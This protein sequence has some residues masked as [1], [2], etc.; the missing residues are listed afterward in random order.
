M[1]ENIKVKSLAKATVGMTVPHLNLR[2]TWARKGAVQLVPFELLEQA[3]FEPG[4]EYLFKTGIL[5]I[6]DLQIRIRLG[7]EEEEATPETAKMIELTDEKIKELL[8]QTALK[9][10]RETIDG[11][12][13]AQ[14]EELANGAIELRITDYQR[15]QILKDKTGKDVLKIVLRENEEDDAEKKTGAGT[16]S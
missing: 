7:L 9:D 16:Q 12:S 5:F 13:L 10:F 14:I 11:L 4:V 6:E 8:T 1:A 3:I 2:R 15:C